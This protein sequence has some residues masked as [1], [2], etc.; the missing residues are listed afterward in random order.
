MDKENVSDFPKLNAPFVRADN[1]S[2]EYVVENQINDG[3]EWVFEDD[4]V[5]AVEKID[6]ANASIVLGEHGDVDSV[7]SRMG[8]DDI[9]RIQ[10][11]GS[12]YPFII[13]GVLNAIKRD[14]LQ[15]LEKGTQHYGEIVGPKVNGNPYDLNEHI[16]VPFEYLYKNVHYESWGDYPK[17][18]SEISGWFENGLI[19]LFYSRMHDIPFDELPED[20]FV[21]GIVFTHP[22]GR[23]AKLRR[24]MFDWYDGE[25]H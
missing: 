4:S 18:F 3:Y 24:D 17:T 21:E 14:W 16:F 8:T 10:T 5:R 22:D 2:G 23:K 20:A 6:G 7:Y 19:P 25:R 12:N 1:E 9:N 13:K 11:F 15:D